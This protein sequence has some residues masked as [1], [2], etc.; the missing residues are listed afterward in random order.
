M[1]IKIS[2]LTDSPLALSDLNID[3][4][5][6]LS[7][8]DFEDT[9]ENRA[10]LAVSQSLKS[11][12]VALKAEMTIATT[13]HIHA[14]L[15]ELAKV[16]DGGHDVRVNNP[17]AVTAAQAGAASAAHSHTEADI[18]D[19]SDAV[20]LPV[21]NE[22]GASLPRGTPVYITGW[23]GAHSRILVALA[24]ADT[25]VKMPAVGL[26]I[27][28]PLAD[29]ANGS[30][31][32]AGVLSG[33]A[34]DSYGTGAAL[35]VAAAGGFSITRPTGSNLIQ[36]VAQVINADAITGS[37]MILGAG[38]TNQTGNL[39]EDNIWVGNPSGL[40]LEEP[41]RGSSFPSS[42][43]DGR[44][45]YHTVDRREYVYD[46]ARTAWLSS[47]TFEHEFASDGTANDGV[48]LSLDGIANSAAFRA[49]P[50]GITITDFTIA[51]TNA[52]AAGS[53]PDSSGVIISE[54]SNDIA[55]FTID[56]GDLSSHDTAVN[57][58]VDAILVSETGF[59]VRLTGQSAGNKLA[60]VLFT[61]EYRLR[62]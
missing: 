22:S 47:Q 40:P 42:P 59:R 43:V 54:R 4:I 36:K 6:A 39:A 55:T 62:G 50:H 38:R 56:D 25:A 29:G 5:P 17:H 3:P 51:Q 46:A 14:N 8:Y 49:I 60:D 2:N 26:I 52:A 13:Q 21:R 20:G 37:V 32:S 57:V 44:R 34:T 41:Y 61:I 23:S 35:Y 7:F 58:D 33:V 9:P 19:L 48:Y 45:F 16:M 10:L 15:K 11:A 24:K 1:A 31:L 27:D 30:V 28:N 18:T 12:I 53:S